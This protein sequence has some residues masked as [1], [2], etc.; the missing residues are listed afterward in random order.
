MWAAVMSDL[1]EVTEL[2]EWETVTWPGPVGGRPDQSAA[3]GSGGVLSGVLQID[4][5][6]I[7]W[8]FDPST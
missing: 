8:R 7:G 2:V 5:D 1:A 4:G 3:A 6:G